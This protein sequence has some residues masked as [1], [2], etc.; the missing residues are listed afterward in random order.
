MI[1]VLRL[2]DIYLDCLRCG[3][4]FGYFGCVLFLLYYFMYSKELDL[5][6][7][8]IVRIYRYVL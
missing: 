6:V 7:I 1:Y 2:S 5:K 3:N 4:I 8:I